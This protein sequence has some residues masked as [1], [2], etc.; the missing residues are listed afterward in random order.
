M[1]ELSISVDSSKYSG[2]ECYLVQVN[3]NGIVDNIPVGTNITAYV[4]PKLQSLEHTQHEYVNVSVIWVSI[5][6]KVLLLW[7]FCHGLFVTAFFVT[8]FVSWPSCHVLLFRPNYHGPLN[9]S[10]KVCH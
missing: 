4:S 7:P 9:L 6:L 3:S 1:G 2:Q 5:S 10:Q 8:A